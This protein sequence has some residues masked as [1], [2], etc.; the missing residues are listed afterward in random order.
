VT[1]KT[2]ASAQ[3][4]GGKGL[5]MDQSSS[6]KSTGKGHNFIHPSNPNPQMGE[7]P[8]GRLTYQ[9]MQD[10]NK[11]NGITIQGFPGM[12][13]NGVHTRF[14]KR[15]DFMGQH[16]S[17]K[18]ISDQYVREMQD[19]LVR[20]ERDFHN[21][22]GEEQDFL[23][24]VREQIAG[25]RRRKYDLMLRKRDEFIRDNSAQHLAK[26]TKEEIER[27]E[28]LDY[29][30][31]FFP[32][33]YGEEVE[34]QRAKLREN[35]KEQFHK[36]LS[37]SGT[38]FKPAWQDKPREDPENYANTLEGRVSNNYISGD[39]PHFLRPAK[40]YPYRRLND[41]HVRDA[42]QE[43]LDRYERDLLSAERERD[44]QRGNVER[45]VQE[46]QM[47]IEDMA[48]KKRRDKEETKLFLKLQIEED[49]KRKEQ[50]N[51]KLKEL[52]RTHFG[53][54]DDNFTT[55]FAKHHD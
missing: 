13:D 46:D 49:L 17:Q 37:D 20:T 28:F 4:C 39:Y 51:Q 54:E 10:I 7:L 19:K 50:E 30:P 6:V 31:N 21:Q 12:W 42:M 55:D 2:Y 11:R 47:K 9:Q 52:T 3:K 26:K 23:K 53:P 32:F 27:K 18:E 40:L 29:R 8:Y 44:R 5:S 16:P 1:P 14:G 35:L 15:I 22:R 45:R 36:H 24:S 25:E 33:T 38:K 43:A 48:E 34:R 41:E